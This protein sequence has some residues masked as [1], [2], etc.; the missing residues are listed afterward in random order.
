VRAE[1]DLEVNVKAKKEIEVIPQH[2][3]YQNAILIAMVETLGV[4]F[5]QTLPENTPKREQ[6]YPKDA[7]PIVT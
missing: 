1:H 3:E 2:L 5:H 4:S 7:E 6:P